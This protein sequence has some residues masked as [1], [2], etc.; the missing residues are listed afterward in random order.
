MKELFIV[1][2]LYVAYECKSNVKTTP[3]VFNIGGV[4]SDN[5][6]QFHFERT[7]QV[8]IQNFAPRSKHLEIFIEIDT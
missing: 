5:N 4:L 1:F 3:N 8:R 2:L 7:I 6:S